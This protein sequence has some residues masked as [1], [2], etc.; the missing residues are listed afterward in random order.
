MPVAG[1]LAKG[2]A[3]IGAGVPIPWRYLANGRYSLE[4]NFG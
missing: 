3:G 1:L 2:L 4:G